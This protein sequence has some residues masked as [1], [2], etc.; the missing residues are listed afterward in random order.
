MRQSADPEKD[1]YHETLDIPKM[2]PDSHSH[3]APISRPWWQA[4][5]VLVLGFLATAAIYQMNRK[6]QA[7]RDQERI[8]RYTDRVESA[9]RAHMGRYEDIVRGAQGFLSLERG[10]TA[11]EFRTYVDGLDSIHRHPGL[12]S[13]A[14]IV[15]VPAPAGSHPDLEGLVRQLHP[16][17]ADPLRPAAPDEPRYVIQYCEPAAQSPNAVGLEVGAS[18]TQHLAADRATDTGEPALTGLLF[19][20]NGKVRQEAVALY[21]PVFRTPQPPSSVAERRAALKGWVSAG[22]LIRPLVEDLLEGEDRGLTFELVD[23]YAAQGPRW[24]Y[25][26]PVWPVGSK[27]VVVHDLSLDGRGWQLRYALRPEFYH[28]EG[29]YRAEWLLVAGLVVSLSLALG[30]ASMAGA[31]ARAVALARRRTTSLRQ[32]LARN[33]SHLEFS[34]LAIIETDAAFRILEWN[35]A[36]ERMF[37]YTRAEM[38]GKDPR[39]LVPAEGQAE[40]DQR[41]KALLKGQGEGIRATLKIRCKDGQT[42]VCDWYL[43]ALR[44][45]EGH[46]MGATYLADDLTDRHRAEDALRQSQKLESLG[47]LAG[48]IAHDFNNLLTAILGNTEVALE[49]IPDDPWLKEALQRIE[50]TTQRGADLARQLLAYAGKGHLAVRPHDINHIIQQMGE[51]LTI[52]ISKK[53]ALC[54]DL[55][56]GL[57]PVEADAAQFQQVVMNLVINASE[58]IGDQSGTVTLRTRAREYSRADLAEGFPGQVLEPGLFVR[59]DVADDGC[60]MDAETIGRIFDPFFSTKFTGRGLGLSAMLGIVRG[61]RAGLHVES[62]P[63]EGTTFTLLFPASEATLVTE[64]PPSEVSVPATGTVLVADDE[65]IIRDLAREALESAGFQVLEARDGQ[66]AVDLFRTHAGRVDLVLLDMTMP[67]MGGAEAFRL[68]RETA[69]SARVLLTSGYTEQESLDA[70]TGLVPN[71]FLQKP[72]RVRDLVTRVRDAMAQPPPFENTK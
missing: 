11:E 71:G 3:E 69:P 43:T 4:A 58:A 12:A 46:F 52:S 57:P 72:F 33:R 17:H 47:V 64:P 1:R 21:L 49:R 39:I 53:V 19:F 62:R 67:R 10:V 20:T 30:V 48:G 25:V 34:P 59:M 8:Q 50:A 28:T 54:Y 36:A 18:Q 61:H 31:R 16:P 70:L 42:R 13:L 5:A 15:P 27:P 9:L 51:L 55:Q 6:A 66:E 32:A 45:E 29:R 41:R 35:P 44:N 2:T 23:P 14:Y 63:G 56:P 22:I 40:L 38:V 24:L 7:V 68:I 60:G 65:A 37:G 26:S